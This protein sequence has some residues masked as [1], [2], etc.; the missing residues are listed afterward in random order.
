MVEIAIIL[1]YSARKRKVKLMAECSV[2]NPA[3]SSLSA[4]GRSNGARLVSARA[5]IKARIATGQRG[6]M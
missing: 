1:V 6:M 4:S 5:E 2:M 3:T